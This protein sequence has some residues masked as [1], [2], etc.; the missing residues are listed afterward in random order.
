MVKGQIVLNA[1]GDHFLGGLGKA[2]RTLATRVE[3][4]HN[5]RHAL[6]LDPAHGLTDEVT[7]TPVECVGIGPF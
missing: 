5:A 3:I 6:R 2:F 4:L 1:A 7:E